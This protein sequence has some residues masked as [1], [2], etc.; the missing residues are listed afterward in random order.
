MATYLI[1]N[2]VVIAA[3]SPGLMLHHNHFS[4]AWLRALIVLLAMT[5]LFDN[6]I[7]GFGIVGYDPGKILGIKLWYVPI[8][9]F[10]YALA[11]MLI[12]PA[13]WRS[14]GSNE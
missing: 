9:D 1:I 6:I 4:R 7:I 5:L 13:L 10:L 11:A 12:V 14:R 3:L 2:L 8:E